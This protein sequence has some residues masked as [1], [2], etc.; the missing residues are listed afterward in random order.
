MVTKLAKTY[1]GNCSRI[2]WISKL[3]GVICTHTQSCITIVPSPST[4][5]PTITPRTVSTRASNAHIRLLQP[6]PILSSCTPLKRKK[7]SSSPDIS[8]SVQPRKRKN[9][10]VPPKTSSS[11][12]RAIVTTNRTQCKSAWKW[13]VIAEDIVVIGDSNLNRVTSS[14]L[15]VYPK[16]VLPWSSFSKS[17]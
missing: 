11:S 17:H 7:L 4:T 14:P 13:P 12:F 16:R 10:G 1:L 2:L 9:S 8:D 3:N 15:K 6:Q 5:K